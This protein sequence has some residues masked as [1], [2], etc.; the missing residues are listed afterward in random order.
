MQPQGKPYL[1]A[2]ADPGSEGEGGACLALNLAGP[3]S[4]RAG[5]DLGAEGAAPAAD[6][7]NKA[8]RI[9]AVDD[10]AHVRA[11][12]GSTLERQGYEVLLASSGREALESL[13]LHTFDLVLTD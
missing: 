12:M 6:P 7:R 11:M 9:L 3:G 2:R 10:E 13:E 4:P 5:E 1:F 8:A